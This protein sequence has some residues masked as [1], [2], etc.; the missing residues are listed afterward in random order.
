MLQTI[1]ERA[2]GWIAWAI[3]ILISIPFALWGIQSYL[4]MGGEPIAATVNGVK[5]PA[6]ELDQRVQE[7]RFELRKRLGTAYD[8]AT[9]DDQRLRAEVL[10]T[11]IQEALLT[12]V[13]KR[14]GLHVS[15]QEVQMQILSDPAF[16][17]EG[18]FDKETYERLLRFQGLTPAM[19]EAQLREKMSATQLIRAVSSSEL[20]TRAELDAYKRLMGQ[21]R[22]ISYLR[23]PLADYR[24]EEPIDEARI[25][26]Y[27]GSNRARFQTPEQV[28]L[29]YLMLDIDSLSSKVEVSEEDLRQ[30]YESDRARFVQPER[31]EVRHLL[32]KVEEGADE[33]K[34]QAVLDEIQAIR[35]RIQAGESF[36]E[37][38]KT[39]SQDPGSAAKGGSL[40]VIESGI[41]VPAF[42]QAAFALKVGELSEP[43][44]TPFG[45][46]LIEVTKIL[47]SETKPFE[48]VREQLRTE[49]AKQ[50]AE[51]LF[52]DLAER[53]ANISYESRDSLDPAAEALGLTVQHSDWIG[54]EG[55]SEGVLSHPKV[56]AAA[57]SEDVLVGGHNSELIEPERDQLQAIVLRVAEHREAS[58]KPL[59]EVRDEIVA[60]I[61]DEQAR[62]A[63]KSAAEALA[64]RLRDGSDWSAIGEGLKPESPGLVDRQNTAVPAGV[65]DAAFKLPV[66]TAGG[67][68]VGT[69]I[70]DDG[71]VVVVRLSKVEDGEVKVNA[72]DNTDGFSAE[73]FILTQ[74]MGRQAYINVI[75]D[76]KSR[77]KIERKAL[78]GRDEAL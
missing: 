39:L 20:V 34:A 27:Y 43:V 54:R 66:P 21:R 35:A 72:E 30:L 50:R 11:L 58:V 75:E 25:T 60:A 71:D 24:R 18:R 40:G 13:V 19:Y 63:A 14:L 36:E 74:I 69:A 41:M 2:Q 77:A 28:K 5:I 62:A 7:R 73:S 64:E 55:G 33:A 4:G 29:D 10:E 26:A 78:R 15:D 68:S 52:Y 57:F 76:M 31:R 49:L 51:G 42:D 44:R 9:F 53:L 6:R 45:Y 70:L 48:E 65:L 46:H 32:L 8:P 12:D 16:I 47:P 67:V 61:R 3:V 59:D 37:L 17:S 56:L 22:E 23:L 38:A 1:R